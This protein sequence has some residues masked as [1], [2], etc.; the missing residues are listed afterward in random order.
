MYTQIRPIFDGMKM[1]ETACVH[2]CWLA[3]FGKVLSVRNFPASI[4]CMRIEMETSRVT[5]DSDII[6]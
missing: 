6:T 2:G 4:L 1:T 5:G 3:V